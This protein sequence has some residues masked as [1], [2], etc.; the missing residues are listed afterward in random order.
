[1]LERGLFIDANNDRKNVSTLSLE[2][3]EER[4]VILKYLVEIKHVDVF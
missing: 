2:T 1:M 3:T 4:K